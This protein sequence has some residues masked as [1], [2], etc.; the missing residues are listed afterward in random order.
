MNPVLVEG[1][2]NIE[3]SLKVDRFPI[4]YCPIHYPFYGVT[5]NVS[6][7][8][9][10]LALALHTLGSPVVPLGLVGRD[11]QG[12]MITGHMQNCGLSTEFVEPNLDQ[13][14]QTVVL[15]DQTG[16]RQIH[17]DLK[18]IQEADYP[19]DRMDLALAR[20]TLAVVGNMNFARP[21]LKKAKAAGKTIVTDVHVIERIDEDYNIEFMDA[22]DI[23]FFSHERVPGDLEAFVRR[24]AETY[25]SQ[26]IVVG[27]GKDG[28]LLYCRD[29]QKLTEFP[30][31]ETRPV[32]NTVGAGDA[33]LA[34]FV[35]FYNQKPDPYD[36][37]GKA[38]VFASYKI[39]VSGAGLGFVGERELLAI[40]ER[41]GNRA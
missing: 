30:A 31:V 4:E 5:A 11:E 14:P 3:T 15:F 16:R 20:C 23:L 33:L 10:N 22:A 1:L 17:N 21:L 2:I 41:L 13:T 12:R 34:A 19:A 9:I 28:A 32:V 40:Q 6:G 27:K 8:G 24:V 35:H 38:M 39:G 25:G 29:G 7:N 37:L 36:A 18:N 26:I